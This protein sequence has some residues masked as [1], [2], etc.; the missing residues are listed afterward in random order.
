[1][2]GRDFSGNESGIYTLTITEEKQYSD[3]IFQKLTSEFKKSMKSYSQIPNWI[4]GKLSNKSPN[5][6]SNEKEEKFD[7]IDIINKTINYQIIAAPQFGLTCYAK[8]LALKAWEIKKENWIYFN[9]D[10]WNFS[11]AISD[12]DDVLSDYN[13]NKTDVK[14]LLLDNWT[15]GTKDSSKV[16]EKLKKIFPEVPFIIMS[17]FQD[18]GIIEGLDSEESHVGFI[19]LYLHELDRKGLRCIVKHFNESQ[20]IAEEDIVLERMNL[21]L[22]D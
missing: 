13:I 6:S 18:S 12:I 15:T 5:V 2:A 3:F 4:E 11:K 7:Y 20:Q 8:Y 22:I 1:M 10:G 9:S 17:N 14:C 21:D 19:Q 16:F